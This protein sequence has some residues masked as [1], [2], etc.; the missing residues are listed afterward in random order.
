MEKTNKTETTVIAKDD[1]TLTL[2][3]KYD[4]EYGH[5]VTIY[6]EPDEYVIELTFKTKNDKKAVEKY[7][8]LK[9]A[10]V[11]FHAYN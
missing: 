10:L 1:I 6:A 9:K 5:S 11:G 4:S 3:L 7:E 2:E 8:L